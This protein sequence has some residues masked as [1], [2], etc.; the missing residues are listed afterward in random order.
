MGRVGGRLGGS[1][2]NNTDMVQGD[3][4]DLV[5]GDETDLVLDDETHLVLGGSLGDIE[6]I[7][8]GWDRQ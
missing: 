1:I 2:I 8:G 4:S 6:D 3:K 7:E 5:L